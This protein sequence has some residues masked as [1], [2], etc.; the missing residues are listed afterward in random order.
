MCDTALSCCSDKNIMQDKVCTN[1]LIATIGTQTIF[2]DNIAQTINA[3]GYVK[4]ETGT[5]TVTVNFF[6]TGI[7]AA[8]KTIVI[9]A[10]GSSSFTVSRFNTISLTSTAAAAQ[11]EFC[12]TVRYS[13]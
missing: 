8:I 10:G 4:F 3:T 6:K 2:S 12:I 7:V 9:P 11:G 1:W 13:I 5:G